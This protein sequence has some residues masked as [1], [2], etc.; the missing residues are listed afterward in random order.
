MTA[1]PT[2]VIAPQPSP[3]VAANALLQAW[4]VGD[5]AVAA[6]VAS[7]SA[8]ATLFAHAPQPVSDRGCQDP[9]GG[10]ASCAF[11]VGS[12]LVTVHTVMAGGGWIVDEVGFD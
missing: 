8:V 11:G 9:V 3:D 12:G 4:Q 2:T 1:P 6:R 5:R 10:Q 7:A